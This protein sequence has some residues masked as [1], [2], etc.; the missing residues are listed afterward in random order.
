MCN[1]TKTGAE[2]K[3]FRHEGEDQPDEKLNRAAL[4]V[5]FTSAHTEYNT[6]E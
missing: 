2:P 5:S 3:G 4:A 1:D 6:A